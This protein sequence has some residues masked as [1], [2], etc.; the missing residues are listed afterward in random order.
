MCLAQALV[1]EGARRL[2]VGRRVE[3]RVSDLGLLLAE[4]ALLDE[5]VDVDEQRVAAKADGD[6]YGE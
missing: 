4:P 2:E 1:L 3:V 5:L 6:W